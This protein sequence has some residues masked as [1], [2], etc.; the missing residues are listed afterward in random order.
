MHSSLLVD[1]IFECTGATSVQSIEQVQSLWSGYGQI[2]RYSLEYTNLAEQNIPSVI[3]KGICPPSSFNHPRGWNTDASAQRKLHSYRVEAQWYLNYAKTASK[4]CPMPTLYDQLCVNDDVFLIMED[5]NTQYPDRYSSL[6]PNQCIAC[7]HWLARFHA[8]HLHHA[9]DHLWP[10]GT[11]WHLQTRQDE[12][13]AMP[14]SDL[15]HAA[16]SLDAQLNKCQHQTLVHGDAK[17]ANICFDKSASN[18]AFVDFQYVG[19]GCGIRDVA[20]FV[21]SCLSAAECERHADALLQSYFD[22][23]SQHLDDSVSEALVAEWRRL[24]PIAWA[25]FHRFL[26]GWMPEHQK[27]NSYTHLMTDKALSLLHE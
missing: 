23:L 26:A 3:V 24:Y 25:D 5:L 6:T 11:Y 1:R 12:F 13:K 16:A 27:I 14:D 22:E 8:S 9:G 7:L 19:K 21:G 17:L 10:I 18:V 20:Y 4:L 2:E 15:K